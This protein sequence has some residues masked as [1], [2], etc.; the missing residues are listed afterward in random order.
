MKPSSGWIGVDLDGTLAD[1]DKWV[2]PDHVGAPVPD[3]V[4]RVKV[5]R[6][7]G[8]RVKI[9]TAR[10]S[11]PLTAFQARKAIEAWCIA[12]LGEALPV[13]NQKDYQMIELWDDR[14]IAVQ[15]N[16]GRILGGNPHHG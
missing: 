9:F 5:W 1:Y 15:K 11:D 3:M 4:D 7:M 2:G 13:T 10:V 6:A 12:H 14:A 16:T 8:Q